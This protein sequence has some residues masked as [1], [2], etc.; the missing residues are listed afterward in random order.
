VQITISVRR[1]V[2]IDDDV[3]SLNINTTAEDISS[4]QNTFLKCFEGGVSADS[5]EETILDIILQNTKKTLHAPFF[6]LKTGMD[7]DARKIAGDKELVQFNGSSD[8]FNEDNNLK[9][10]K[11][12]KRK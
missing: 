2:I 7:T 10:Q 4:D 8:R 11:M 1:A 5:I 6:L 12:M 9:G 3:H